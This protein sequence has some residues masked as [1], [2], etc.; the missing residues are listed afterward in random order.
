MYPQGPSAKE[1]A[2]GHWETI[3]TKF[4]VPKQILSRRHQSCPFC[5]GQ[6]RFRFKMIGGELHPDGLWVCNQCTEASYRDGIAFLAEFAHG[7]DAL[8]ACREIHCFLD[9]GSVE[10]Q[11]FDTGKFRQTETERRDKRLWVMQKILDESQ[12]VRSGDAVDQYL[13]NRVPGLPEVPSGI[14]MHRQLQYW[15]PPGR[16]GKKPVLRGRFPSMLVAGH[17]AAGSLVQIH[18]TFLNSSGGKAAVPNPKK[19]D[20]GVGANSFALRLWP[21][22]EIWG[23]TLAVSEGIETG[24]AGAVRFGVPAWACHSKDVMARFTLPGSLKTRIKRLIILADNDLQWSEH[25]QRRI[26]PGM[27]AARTLEKRVRQE[28]AIKVEIH[29]TAKAKTDM[30]DLAVA[31]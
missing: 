2:R 18:K 29:T 6:D 28:W 19:T 15:D 30:A 7:G 23:D 9:G 8:A 1:R 13:R 4:G 20:M 5:G 25:L 12:A 27:Q 17:S 3:L 10:A 26:N 14:R 31:A 24:L 22:A 21:E 11:P 16:E